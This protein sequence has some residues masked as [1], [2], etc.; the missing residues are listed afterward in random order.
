MADF[1]VF[2]TAATASEA[3]RIDEIP[4]WDG[5]EKASFALP[6]NLSGY[7]AISVCMGFGPRSLPLAVQIGGRPFDEATLFQVASLLESS[8]PWR[9]RRPTL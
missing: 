4:F 6:W 2:V 5:L 8:T 7:P 9:N 1:D 3:S